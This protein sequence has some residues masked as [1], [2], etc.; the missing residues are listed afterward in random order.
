MFGL[1]D[2]RLY[3]NNKLHAA[4]ADVSCIDLHLASGNS[5]GNVDD[6]L[7]AASASAM[8]KLRILLTLIFKVH[9]RNHN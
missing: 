9:V 6:D 1:A 2:S 3:N 4:A 8:V 7:A 5:S